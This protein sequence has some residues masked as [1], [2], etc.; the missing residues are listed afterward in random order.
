MTVKELYDRF[1]ISLR[2]YNVCEQLSLR[3]IDD[4]K[5]FL[6]IHNDFKSARNCGEKTN[7]ELCE[8]VMQYNGFSPHEAGIP[9]ELENLRSEKDRL[10]FDTYASNLF[11]KLSVRARNALSTFFQGSCPTFELLKSEFLHERFDPNELQN[12]GSLTSKEIIQYKDSLRN[13]YKAILHDSIGDHEKDRIIFNSIVGFECKDNLFIKKFSNNDFPL[14]SF[15]KEN[16]RKLFSLRDVD[17]FILKNRLHLM[18]QILSLEEIAKKFNL[19]RERIRQ[20]SITVLENIHQRCF[21]LVKLTSY[22]NCKYL[23]TKTFVPVHELT[24]P[25]SLKEDISSSSAVFASYFLEI[26]LHEKFYSF[27]ALDKIKRPETIQYVHK[28]DEVKK[29]KGAYLIDKN[30]FPKSELL[31][32][33]RL[34]IAKFSERRNEDQIISFKELVRFAITSEKHRIIAAIACLEFGLSV[35]EEGVIFPRNSTRLIYEYV[36]EALEKI[37]RPAH[38]SEIYEEVKKLHPD[39]DSGE[40]ALR[41]SLG[42][43]KSIFIYF[44]RSSTYGLKIWEKER[45]NIKGGTIKSIIEEY[46]A[47]EPEPK[48]ISEILNHLKRFRDTSYNSVVTNLKLDNKSKFKFYSGGY[49]GLTRKKYSNTTF[50]VE[51]KTAGEIDWERIIDLV[52]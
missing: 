22:S 51:F 44:G 42:N 33:Y 6:K 16:L 35:S 15:I 34:L 37:N 1:E 38:I 40:D 41:G 49:I 23:F 52:F 5:E 18:P 50:G 14:I 7:K 27:S 45:K 29:V 19:S 47:Q 10:V 2:A 11:D 30:V 36:V 24:D 43:H 21:E 31:E 25:I 39:Y 12:V 46:L 20:K 3:S 9:F 48:H 13:L 4:L 17:E 32:L 28:Y 26:F 8:I